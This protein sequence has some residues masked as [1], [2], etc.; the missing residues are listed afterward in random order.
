LN[1]N[2]APCSLLLPASHGPGLTLTLLIQFFM[3]QHNVAVRKVGGGPATMIRCQ[4][5]VDSS[6][7]VAFDARDVQ[8]ALV[9]NS[10]Y[11]LNAESSSAQPTSWTVNEAGLEQQVIERF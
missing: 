11:E 6:M 9:A 4:E 3:E 5:I 1:A 2:E 7:L 10:E 8:L